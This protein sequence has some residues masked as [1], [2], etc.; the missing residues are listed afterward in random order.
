MRQSKLIAAPPRLARSVESVPWATVLL[1]QR[2]A[3]N[4]VSL[5]PP[6]FVFGLSFF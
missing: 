4:P 6:H 5:H 2:A 1:L 3:Q